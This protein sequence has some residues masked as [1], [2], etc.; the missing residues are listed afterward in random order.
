MI[1]VPESRVSQL[2]RDKS[3]RLLRWIIMQR[4][5][6]YLRTVGR[7]AVNCHLILPVRNGSRRDLG[8]RGCRKH[9][10]RSSGQDSPTAATCSRKVVVDCR[11]WDRLVLCTWWRTMMK[12]G[13]LRR[14]GKKVFACRRGAA[15][16]HPRDGKSE[17]AYG[18]PSKES[19]VERS[20]E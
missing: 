4:I 13:K 9:A 20:R 12:A 19:G 6:R 16:A 5:P 15:S 8:L 3:W 14:C 10:A 1:Y 2:H 11:T 7:G 17:V 18:F